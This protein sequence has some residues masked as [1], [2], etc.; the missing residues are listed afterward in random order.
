[1]NEEAYRNLK[2]YTFLL[3]FIVLFFVLLYQGR[4]LLIP[5]SFGFLISFILYPVCKWFEKWIGRIGGIF[6]CLLLLAAFGFVLFQLIASSF[7][8]LQEKLATSQDRIFTFFKNILYYLESYLGIDAGQ[9]QAIVQ[10]FYEN[11]LKEIFPLL[12]QTI[13]LSAS[14]LATVLIV[15]IFVS[16]ILY[17]RGLLVKFLLSAVPEKQVQ[18]YKT[19]IT[20]LGSTYFR[21]A[22]GMAMVYLIVG[23]LN[24]IGFLA[25]GLPNAVYFGILASLLTFFPYIGIMIGGLAAVI[26]AWTTYD[27]LW[28]PAAVVFILGVVQ[29]LEANV[30]FPLIVGHQLKINPFATFIA[31]IIGG[32]V[33]GGA[34]MILFVPFAAILKILADQLEE[35]HPLAVF[36]SES[37]GEQPEKKPVWKFWK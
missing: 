27:S 19:T 34:G 2:F 24:S 33:W 21:F 17:Y 3:A 37:E 29:Y 25:I 18:G 28:Y 35:L 8:L 1:M 14:S 26:V 30:I 4:L 22:K 36:L 20:Q 5:L 15:P 7:T 23:I 10:Q 32:M 16:L 13:F 12:K 9:Q 11:L 31:I 6:V